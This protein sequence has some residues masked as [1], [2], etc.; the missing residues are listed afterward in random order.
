MNLTYFTNKFSNN[1]KKSGGNRFN[2][3]HKFVE[4]SLDLIEMRKLVTKVSF[5]EKSKLL[6]CI[7]IAERKKNWHYNREEF[8]MKDANIIL[9]AI[10]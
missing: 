3:T 5:E 9:S 1:N 4:Y 6:K 10:R 7:E 8:N 2:P